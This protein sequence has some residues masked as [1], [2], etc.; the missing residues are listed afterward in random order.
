MFRQKYNGNIT[1][2]TIILNFEETFQQ[3]LEKRLFRFK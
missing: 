2:E 3:F 1:F